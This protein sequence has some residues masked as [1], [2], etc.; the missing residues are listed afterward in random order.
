MLAYLEETGELDNTIVI[1]TSDNG[2]P[3]PRAKANSY[4]YGIHVP[5]AVRFPK[6]FPAGRSVDDPISFADLAPTILEL[7]GTSPEGMLPISG[8]SITHILTSEREGVVDKNKKY[9]FAGRERHSSSRYRNWGYPQ[10]S[11]RS[12]DFLLIWNLKPDRWPAGA[13]QRLVPGSPGELYPLYGIDENGN[14]QSDW[15]FTDIDGSPSK[16]FIIE[17]HDDET[18]APY[19]QWATA[20]RPE[21]EFFHT[22]QDPFCLRNLSGDPQYEKIEKEMKKALLDELRRSGDPRITGPDKEVFD[23]YLRYSP[24][25]EFPDPAQQ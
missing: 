7:T 19:F 1:V 23:S 6:D 10:R 25:R 14:Q 21:F 20:K 4:E 16:A 5:F 12:K 8:K 11:V 2:M 18:I 22:A 13:P 17:H 9:I 15:A 24:M 3:F